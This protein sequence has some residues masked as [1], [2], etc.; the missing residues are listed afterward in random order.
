MSFKYELS[1]IEGGSRDEGSSGNIDYISFVPRIPCVGASLTFNL[2]K[3]LFNTYILSE[4]D[5]VYTLYYNDS[6]M[7]FTSCTY[8]NTY[9]F[10]VYHNVH[11]TTIQGEQNVLTQ[12]H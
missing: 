5:S 8:V 7:S 12:I 10:I 6:I 11:G 1:K 4:R 2:W 9:L 3:L